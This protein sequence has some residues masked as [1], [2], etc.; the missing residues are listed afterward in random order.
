MEPNGLVKTFEFNCFYQEI[1]CFIRKSIDVHIFTVYLSLG[2]I[3]DLC[4]FELQQFGASLRAC[5]GL[6]PA[7]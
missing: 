1:N 2:V 7:Q 4:C 5:H 3:R 6:G